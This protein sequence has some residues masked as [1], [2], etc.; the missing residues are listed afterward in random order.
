MI[1]GQHNSLPAPAGTQEAVISSIREETAG[2]KTFTI[3]TAS[4]EAIP[5]CP[6]QFITLVFTHHGREDRRSY[7]IS[8][9]PASD[10]QLSFTVKRIDNGAYSRLLTDKAKIGDNLYTT[11]VAGLFT[12][13]AATDNY[14]QLFF[15]AAGIGITPIYSL[16]KTLLHTEQ[17]KYIVL[18]YSNSR[19]EDVV[20]YKELKELTLAFPGHFRIEYLF[21]NS[22]NL[23]RARLSKELLPRLLKEYALYPKEQMLFYICGPFNYM[24]MAIY[25]LQEQGIKDEQIKKENFNTNDRPVMKA[26]FVRFNGKATAAQ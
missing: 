21:S 2:V 17:E 25:S 11:G 9:S 20:F 10:E 19:P 8:S 16:I 4:G 24:R 6:G 7:S 22:F 14:R 1:A 15:F 26:V 5:Y 13:S 18:I 12:L 3:T 23:Q